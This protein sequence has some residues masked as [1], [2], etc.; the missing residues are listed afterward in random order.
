VKIVTDAMSFTD[1]CETH[2][3]KSLSR[4]MFY[5]SDNIV[6]RF[7]K[8][9]LD[10]AGVW[11]KQV[12]KKVLYREMVKY[13]KRK[14]RTAPPQKMFFAGLRK[15]IIPWVRV[16]ELVYVPELDVCKALNLHYYPEEP[17]S[18]VECKK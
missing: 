13:C 4:E 17:H 9:R 8:D 2:G 1:Y 6:V 3:Y 5:R 18:I 16:G 14:R 11:G 10:T 12:P 7:W 15:I